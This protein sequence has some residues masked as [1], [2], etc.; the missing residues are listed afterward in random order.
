VR[1]EPSEYDQAATYH[2]QALALAE[3]LDMRP[4]VAHYHLGLGKLYAGVARRVEARVELS[5]AV[6]LYRAMEMTFWLPQAET[7]LAQVEGS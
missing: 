5:A 1:R 2:R 4:L 3:E 7:A 6:E